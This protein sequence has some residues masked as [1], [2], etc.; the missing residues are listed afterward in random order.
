MRKGIL[1]VVFCVLILIAGCKKTD[2]QIDIPY[3]LQIDRCDFSID[4]ITQG[5]MHQKITD[6]YVL[7]DG[8]TYGYYPIPCKVPLLGNSPKSVLLRPVIKVNGVATVRSDYAM[9]K[10]IDTVLTMEKGKPLAVVPKFRYYPS[11]TFKW[12]ENFE[13]PS[14]SMKKN[15]TTDS[16]TITIDTVEKFFGKK[17]LAIRPASNG[18][19]SIAQ[20]I[21]SFQLPQGGGKNIYLEISYRCNQAFEVGILSSSLIDSRSVGGGLPSESW[22]KLYLNLTEQANTPPLYSSYYIYIGATKNPAVGDPY[23][24]IDNIKLISQ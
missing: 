8:K 2:T 12:L 3:Y 20:S 5:S 10:G 7:A 1:P 21:N 19:P 18:I 11:V 23:I 15:A 13:G 6:V 24:L 14:I 9:M 4:S 17:C 22:N 16:T